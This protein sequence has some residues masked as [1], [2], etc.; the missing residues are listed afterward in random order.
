MSVEPSL[1]DYVTFREYRPEDYNFI[2]SNWAKSYRSS[3][4]SGPI[5]NNLYH[6]TLKE[7]VDQL[8]G[9][10]AYVVLA[11]SED[12]DDQFLGFVCWEQAQALP[13][14]HY[15]FVKD[16]FREI[17]GLGRALLRVATKDGDFIYTHKTL[18]EGAKRLQKGGTFVKAI[19]CRK[20]LEPVCQPKRNPKKKTS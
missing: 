5:P 8:L 9:R 14:V 1:L 18:D 15:V 3:P 6:A 13:V 11:V 10:G 2:L 19:A 4:Y 17:H 7:L 16:E 12:D 20:N